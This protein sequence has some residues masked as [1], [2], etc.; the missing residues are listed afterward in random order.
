MNHKGTVGT[1]LVLCIVLVF[2]TAYRTY[3][4]Y[5]VPSNTFDWSKRGH[6]DFHYGTYL[7]ATA[8]R[9]GVNPYAPEVME[10]YPVA[11]PSRPCPPITFILHLPFT[12]VDMETADVIFF[13]YNTSLLFLLSFVAVVLGYG[14]FHMGW[15]L[16]VSSLLLVSRPGHISLFTGYYTLELV[17]GVL[18]ALHFG[19]NRPWLSA[20]GMLL[21]SVK[22]TYILPLILLMIA[23]KNFRAVILGLA[24]CTIAGVG[25]LAWLAKDSSF[26][27]VVQGISAGQEAFHADETEFPVNTWTRVDLLGMFAKF[28]DWI[29]S[30][31]VYLAS[32][33]VIALIPCIA[34]WRVAERENDSSVLGNSS[35]LA[36]L[37][38]LLSIYHHSYDCLLIAVPWIGVSFFPGRV[39]PGVGARTKWLLAGLLTVPMV[40]YA[41]T[42]SA[43]NLLGLEQSSL[44]W[45]VVTVI[46]GVS[47]FLALLIV[48][49]IVF[50]Q[51]QSSPVP[52]DVG[53]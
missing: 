20:V 46:N 1:L 40:N 17:M 53:N 30:D 45:Q 7:P 3:H 51:A 26:M 33:F 8:F 41:S 25:G 47:L 12:F 6:S 18:L 4:D 39:L 43:R 24:L 38:L 9:K 23:R 35:M 22:P 44:I 37:T 21:A 48:M 5:S 36:L 10:K 16:F 34:I 15:W 11:S 27:E 32:M 31:K 50:R 14:R 2:A 28:V 29:P 19:K 52:K 13:V 42:Q 49:A